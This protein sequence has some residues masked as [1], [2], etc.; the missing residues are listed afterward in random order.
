[1]ANTAAA[2]AAGSAGLILV[3]SGIENKSALST[4]KSI[5]AGKAPTPGPGAVAPA[6]GFDI[7]TNIPAAQGSYSQSALESLWTDNGGPADTAAFAAAVGMAESGGNP[8][9]T[10][11]NPDGGTNVGVFQLDT[12]GVG[13]GYSVAELSDPNL[14]TQVTIMAT[15]GGTDWSEWGDPVT[16]AVGYH[17]TPGGPV[18]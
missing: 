4:L 16:A 12:T 3:W 7:A 14:N 10:S 13:G 8:K 5:I 1:M 15:G 18:P 11:A 9:A 17:Y 6:A 2:I